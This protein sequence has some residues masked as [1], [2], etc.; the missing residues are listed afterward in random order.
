[1]KTGIKYNGIVLENY[2]AEHSQLEFE[3]FVELYLPDFLRLINARAA[4][5]IECKRH[6]VIDFLYKVY[7]V[8]VDDGSGNPYC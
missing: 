6:H 1:M 5:G 3:R 8:G 4:D 2:D 7:Q